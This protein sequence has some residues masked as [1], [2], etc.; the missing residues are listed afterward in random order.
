MPSRWTRRIRRLLAT[1]F[2]RLR[3]DD[4][5]REMAFHVE[6]LAREYERGGMNPADA[7]AAAQRRFGD[8][9]RHRE[10]G[11]DIRGSALL[12]GVSR[13]VRHTARG[14]MKAPGFVLGVVL[15]LAIGIGANTAIF[16][17]VDQLLLRPLP[18]PDGERLLTVHE[19]FQDFGD[20]EFNSVSPANWLDWQ[21]QSRTLGALAMW[22]TTSYTL[23][24]IG[25][26]AR[27]N[28]Q[29]VTAE[30]FPLLGVAP[31]LGRVINADDDRPGA[32]QVAVLSHECWRQRFGSDPNVVGRVVQLSDNPFQ[33]VGVMPPGFRLVRHDTDLWTAL[34][35]DRAARWRENAGRF[36]NV[37]ARLQAGAT[38]AE[39]RTEL[40]TIAAR[41]SATYEFNKRTGV[42]LTPLRESLTANVAGSLIALYA[43]VGVLL[44]IACVNVANLG[45][46]LYGVTPHDPATYA[47][48]LVLLFAVSALASYVPARRA[49]RVQ[50]LEALRQD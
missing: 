34:R 14:L 47:G 37:V 18:Y 28:A 44:T 48:G 4:M 13:D 31:A 8:A 24:G 27:V 39:A 21:S 49:A 1:V 35:L 33:V 45:T 26:P 41:L 11:H 30:F 10:R 50:P 32:P 9:T 43:A 19:T 12:D 17:V 2:W 29:T 5:E 20:V 46:L 23:T 40:E 38:L 25:A 3:H 15:T 7:R 16:S 36:L 22:G 6:Q 42:R